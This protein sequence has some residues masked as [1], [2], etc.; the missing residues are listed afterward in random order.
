MPPKKKGKGPARAASSPAAADDDAMAIDSPQ[1]HRA[2]GSPQPKYNILKDPWTDDQETS[3]FKGIIR[4]KPAGMHK[5]F[6]MIALSENL[7]NHGYD[8]AIET[9]TRIPGI[10]E[11]LRTQ[12]NLDIIDERE[13][14][15]DYED[16]DDKFLEFKLPEDYE[17]T[18]HMRGMRS[19]SEAPSS[20][21]RLH[22]S[23]SPQVV[24]KRKRGDTLTQKR[25]AS[26][27][28]DTDEPKTSPATSPTPKTAR[29][30]RSAHRLVGRVKADSSSR[31]PSKDTT[32]D[33]A[34][35]EE[36]TE[37]GGEDDEAEGEEEDRSPSP[38]A[39]KPASRKKP[40]P[41][42]KAQG[43]SRKSKRKR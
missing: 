17:E 30:G 25:R 20:P 40:E 24:R 29:A 4:W 27:V 41:P 36:E 8:P 15:F 34:E 11:K 31:Q 43:A 1:S 39:S 38:E 3:L 26:T 18:M 10:W 9:H 35:V 7:R 14:S 37:E 23:P 22:R 28:E 32:M 2:E 12:Y 19:A 13:N 33:E 6:R 5:H 42:P 16:G 21:P